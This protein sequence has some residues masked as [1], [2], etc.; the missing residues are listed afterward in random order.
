MANLLPNGKE[1]RG[2]HVGQLLDKIEA[3]GPDRFA[4]EDRFLVRRATKMYDEDG[5]IEDRQL[6]GHLRKIAEKYFPGGVPPPPDP[7]TAALRA[8]NVALNARL[9]ALEAKLK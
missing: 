5:G 1:A 7:A 8:E 3:E 2:G 9:A 4:Q 6:L